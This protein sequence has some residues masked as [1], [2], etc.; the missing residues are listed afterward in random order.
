MNMKNILL[1]CFVT[2]LAVLLP[3]AKAGDIVINE[4]MYHPAPA[5][6]DDPAREW[7]ELHNKGTNTIVLTGWRFEKGVNFPFPACTIGPL[8]Y[9]VVAANT[10]AFLGEHPGFSAARVVGNWT[11]KLR[12]SGEE[13]QLVDE[14]GQPVNAVEYSNEGN[15]ALRRS[16]EA[17]PGHPE[18]WRGWQWTTT[19]DGGGN[20]LELRNPDM[21]NQY[22]QNWA[23][24]QLSGGTPGEPNSV[25]TNKLAPMI[26]EARH[27]PLI[28]KSTNAVTISA[29][30]I[31]EET[32]PAVTLQYR[33]DGTTSFTAV[34]MFD[35]GQ[36]GDGLASDGVYGAILPAR[37]DKTIVEYYISAAD[38]NGNRRTWPGPTDDYGTQGANALY[39][40]DDSTYA[41]SQS[42]YRAVVRASEWT[43]WLNLM[44]NVSSGRY[45]DA[46]MNATVI[47][48]DGRG[49]E[50]RYNCDVRNRGAGTRAAHPHNFNMSFPAER[51]LHGFTRLDFNTRTV[52]SQVAGK[53]VIT[54]AGL[55]N[56]YGAPVQ[57]RVNGRNLANASPT[58]GADS[59]QFGSY[60][61]FEPYN[62]EWAGVHFPNDLGGNIYKGVWYFDGYGLNTP[63]NL[64]YLGTNPASYKLA[65]TPSGP[66]SYT[67]P[68]SKQSNSAEDD[69]SDLIQLTY[70]ANN[71]TGE[72][73]L[74]NLNHVANVEEWLNYC[75]VNTLLLNME[76]TLATGA[77]DDY[78]MYRGELDPRFVVLCHD[79]DTSLAQGDAT[80]NYS[81]SIFD[82]AIGGGN[83]P[84]IHAF[85]LMLKHPAIAPRYY[86]ILKELADTTFS[87]AQINPLLDQVLGGWVPDSYIQSMKNAARDRRTN[88][89]WQIPLSLSMTSSIAFSQGYLY[90]TNSTV[91]LFGWANAIETRSVRVNGSSANWSAWE[92]R[93][94][95]TITLV[96]GDQ[97]SAGPSHE[98]ER[99]GV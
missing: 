11:G 39:Q 54:A 4:I 78:F 57:V 71:L 94:T 9:L 5:V 96:P 95:N 73:Y 69:W 3:H 27:L 38:M 40:V 99:G 91:T 1:S 83:R 42:V 68:Y 36:H 66:T 52:H 48:S 14:Q 88:V 44:D 82:A 18:W 7:I 63:A 65:Y 6:P 46:A 87:P 12:N 64:E 50:V 92:A 35:D 25:A 53:A 74:E 30:I 67:G 75:A 60:Y 24:S 28:P 33:V 56:A 61:C 58:G 77:G 45:S 13:I 10:N 21:P 70:A 81:K 19:A 49:A 22:G 97:P 51:P 62:S 29:R 72:D 76:T 59:F 79:L 89:L 47:L 37:A 23:A 2:G 90:T 26:L 85:D 32:N 8:A 20:S 31:D 16:G 98:Y 15:W 80:P 55:P 84:G 43:A 34:T 86:A 17:Y 93:W 41:G